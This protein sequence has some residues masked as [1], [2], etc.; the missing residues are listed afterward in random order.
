MSGSRTWGEGRKGVCEGHWGSLGVSFG[1]L[2]DKSE[3][4]LHLVPNTLRNAKSQRFWSPCVSWSQLT[5]KKLRSD[6]MC[7]G[8]SWPG[9]D[10]GV[11]NW[12]LVLSHFLPPPC[13]LHWR[14][15][16]PA[17]VGLPR[18]PSTGWGQGLRPELVPRCLNGFPCAV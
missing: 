16:D 13:F 2:S 17:D 15:I 10:R 12:F 18:P 5:G 7:P 11:V 4:I 8:A 3:T 9:K 1:L 14:W 6:V